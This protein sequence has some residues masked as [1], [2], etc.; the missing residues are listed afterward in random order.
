MREARGI[1]V[2]A[3]AVGFRPVDPVPEVAGFDFVAIHALAAALAIN[4][5]QIHAMF[6][7]DQRKGLLDVGAQL[8][9]R[10]RPAGV[11]T[12]DGKAAPGR[13]AEIFETANVI[14][15]P[16]MERDRDPGEGFQRAI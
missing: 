11:M 13:D 4:R 12:G 1:E 16:A 3:E 15:L 6:A 2:K 8:V 9:R 5:V 7:G 14:T 10:A